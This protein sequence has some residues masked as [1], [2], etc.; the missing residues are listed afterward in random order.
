MPMNWPIHLNSLGVSL[1][2]V[3]AHD[4]AL[5]NFNESLDIALQIGAISSMLLLLRPVLEI[6]ILTAENLV[7]L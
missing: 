3:L 2:Y 1:I 7:R 6:R 4:E 5:R